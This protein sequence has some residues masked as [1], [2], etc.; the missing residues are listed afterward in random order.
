[1]MGGGFGGSTINLIRPAAVEN[2]RRR[3]AAAYCERYGREP[4]IHHCR[5]AAGAGEITVQG[6]GV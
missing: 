3:I 6:A 1:M 4:E 5:T 2:F